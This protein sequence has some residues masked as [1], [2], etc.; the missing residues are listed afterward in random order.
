MA[1]TVKIGQ[2]LSDCTGGETSF[3]VEG[4]TF[5]ELVDAI[6]AVHPGFRDQILTGEL[7]LGWLLIEGGGRGAGFQLASDTVTDGTTITITM[8]VPGG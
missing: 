5:G 7:P 1:V 6:E 3:V 4:K 2:S 8:N